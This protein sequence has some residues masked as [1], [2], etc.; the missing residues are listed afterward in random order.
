MERMPQGIIVKRFEVGVMELSGG[1]YS[2][3]PPGRQGES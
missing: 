2:Q 1:V 3:P